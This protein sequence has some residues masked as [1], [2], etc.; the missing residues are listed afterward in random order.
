MTHLDWSPFTVV[1]EIPPHATVISY[2]T[3]RPT[4]YLPALVPSKEPEHWFDHKV[5]VL[6]DEDRD[7]RVLDALAHVIYAAPETASR[8]SALGEHKGCLTVWLGGPTDRDF[9][10]L[11]EA[12]ESPRISDY[13][14]VEI[15]DMWLHG[16][17]VRE[18][19]KDWRGAILHG[20]YESAPG[21][22][23]PAR[24]SLLPLSSEDSLVAHINALYPLGWWSQ[25]KPL[26]SES[27]LA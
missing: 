11:Q 16:P 12:A 26:S 9:K 6:W 23:R 24:S 21:K 17:E 15:R 13:W 18:S 8:I 5:A 20:T 22:G 14:P 3:L 2:R 27:L 25:P 4:G 19:L 1:A 7:T 10:A